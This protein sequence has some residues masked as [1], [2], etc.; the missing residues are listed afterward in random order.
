MNEWDPISAFTQG[1]RFRA[2]GLRRNLE[3][4]AARSDDP[5]VRRLVAEVLAGQKTV[6]ELVR[7]ETFVGE[8]N[9]GMKQFA[10]SWEQLTPEQRAAL[11]RQGQAEESARRVAAG[12]PPLDEE[13]AQPGDS[14]LLRDDA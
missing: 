2:D 14:P 10:D 4:I 6:R 3:A 12:L 9:K 1:D 8:L 13:P 7:D 5:H 11:V